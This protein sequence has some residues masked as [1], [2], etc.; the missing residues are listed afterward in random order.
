MK[1]SDLIQLLQ[2][3]HPHLP[4][5]DVELA[6]KGLIQQMAETLCLGGRIEIRGFGSFSVRRREPR[7]RRNP[8]TGEAVQVEAHY[9]LHFKP[10]KELREGVNEC[11]ASEI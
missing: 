3:R 8:K 10:G 5:S 6:V 11:A 1:K 4:A 7:L 9:A 2:Q